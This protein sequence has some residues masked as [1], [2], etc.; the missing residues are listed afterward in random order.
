MA[1]LQQALY[2]ATGPDTL[3]RQQARTWLTGR[4]RDFEMVVEFAGLDVDAVQ[5]KC[6][7][8][9]NRRWWVAPSWRDSLTAHA[10]TN[11]FAY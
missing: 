11:F 4:S 9:Y 8:L 2:D 10:E 7:A 6:R 3:D 1:V 5:E